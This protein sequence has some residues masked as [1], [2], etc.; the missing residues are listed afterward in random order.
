MRTRRSSRII[1]ISV[2][3]ILVILSAVFLYFFYS[4]KQV[5]KPFL[6]ESLPPVGSRLLIIAP[7]CD[8]ETLGPGVLLSRAL[9]AGL[10]VK[11][12]IV[13]NGDGF[14]LA[15][16]EDFFT[17]HP[18]SRDYREFGYQRQQE[19]INA[20]AE[21]GLSSN[22]IYLLGYPDTGVAHLWTEFWDND[23]RYFSKFTQTNISPYNDSFNKR[24]P[25]TGV[26]LLTDLEKIVR[27]YK[28]THIYYPHP[29]DRHPDHWGVNAFVKY[30][31]EANHWRNIQ[32]RLYLVHRGNWPVPKLPRPSMELYPPVKL[33]GLGTEWRDFRFQNAEANL[34]KSAILQY[35]TQIRAMKGFLLAFVRSS[36]LFGHYRDFTLPR[37]SQMLRD[38]DNDTLAIAD[39]VEDV[40][41]RDVDRSADIKAIYSY[42]ANDKWVIELAA[43]KPV[44]RDT[45]YR[46]HARL[47]FD[48]R[49][50]KRFDINIYRSDTV[51]KKYA[52]DSLT[53]FPGMKTTNINGRWRIEIPLP[54]LG[55]VRAVFM[56]ADSGIG[57][58]NVDK[59][60]WRMLRFKD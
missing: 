28:P 36:E 60:A 30:L 15:V 9:K 29:L 47:F 42:V 53:G 20:L 24:A 4:P 21:L 46:I 32:E 52:R 6:T 26:S 14:T 17:M 13:T 38:S 11:V 7:H 51:F 27:E 35:H 16:D 34:K 57:H 49:P 5:R 8:D 39:P 50:N 1:T 25:Y 22:D 2:I 58:F 3:I 55:D 10:K 33:T 44:T 54:A 12:I 31:L 40:V 41:T 23:K 48:D 45:I 59:T 19:S 56:N 37:K 18:S 43:V